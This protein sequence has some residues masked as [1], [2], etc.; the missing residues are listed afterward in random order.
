MFEIPDLSDPDYR[1][2]DCDEYEWEQ[3]PAYLLS[4]YLGIVTGFGFE[5]T[6]VGPEV[7]RVGYAG[8]TSF[9]HLYNQPGSCS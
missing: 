6:V 7:Y 5:R 4:Y 8:N 9:V 1:L 2:S 3:Y